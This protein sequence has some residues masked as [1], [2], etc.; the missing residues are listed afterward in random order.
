M[1]TIPLPFIPLPRVPPRAWKIFVASW[2]K[3]Q[4][5]IQ[6]GFIIPLPNIPLSQSVACPVPPGDGQRN[7]WQS[8]RLRLRRP[9]RC[10]GFG[11]QPDEQ[12]MLCFP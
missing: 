1:F 7:V 8:N 11:N 2:E 4:Q 6:C 12:A 9:M 3:F 10:S 5:N